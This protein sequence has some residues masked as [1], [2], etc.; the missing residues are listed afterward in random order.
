MSRALK[1]ILVLRNCCLIQK[2]TIVNARKPNG[3][4]RPVLPHL[5]ILVSASF[6]TLLSRGSD[7]QHMRVELQGP[8][9]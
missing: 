8:L 3:R 2:A 9:S 7:M 5:N 1:V 6:L 4:A